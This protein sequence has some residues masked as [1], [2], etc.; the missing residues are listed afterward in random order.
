M[1]FDIALHNV[2]QSPRFVQGQLHNI[3][4]CEIRF[5]MVTKH[6]CIR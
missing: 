6:V 5:C 4:R 1:H 2:L 3:F